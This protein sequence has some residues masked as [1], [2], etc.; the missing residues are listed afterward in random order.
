MSMRRCRTSAARSTPASQLWA[1]TSNEKSRQ[2]A[3]MY[4]TSDSATSWG[5][6]AKVRFR[7]FVVGQRIEV[8]ERLS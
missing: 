1:T 7:N 4:G 8:L 3:S 2:P 6:P 5:E